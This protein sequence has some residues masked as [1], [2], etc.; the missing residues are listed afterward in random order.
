MEWK[1]IGIIAAVSTTSGF[2]PQ[3]LRGIRTKK[4]EDVSPLMYI[5]IIFGFSM[6]LSYGIHLKDVIIIGANLVALIFSAF[7]LILRYKYLKQKNKVN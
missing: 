2:I 7:I 6:W 3:L 1:I 4:L 5:V